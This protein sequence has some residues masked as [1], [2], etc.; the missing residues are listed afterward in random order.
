MSNDKTGS[1]VNAI[2]ALQPTEKILSI[3]CP[4]KVLSTLRMAHRYH[5]TAPRRLFTRR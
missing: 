1:T 5:S 3:L 4:P 2:Q